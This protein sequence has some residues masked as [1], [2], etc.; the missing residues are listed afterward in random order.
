MQSN[1]KGNKFQVFE[2]TDEP[3]KKVLR[4]ITKQRLKNIGLFY[5]KRFE[6][7]VSNLRVVL[8]RRVDQYARQNPDFDR[9]Q[10]FDWIEELLADFERWGYLDDSR[11]AEMKIRDYLNAG[12]PEK[13]IKGKLFQK[14]IDQAQVEQILET[15]EYDPFEMALKL[16]RKKKIGP[17]RL[18]ETLR[19]ENRQKDMGVL[20]RA[21]FDYET[22][23]DVLNTDP[24][25]V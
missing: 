11:Y 2:S 9:L 16:A 25:S 8:R 7:S 13:Y 1:S 20:I 17:F 14:G 4:K 5:L 10:A 21:G 22:V 12:K 23:M 6:S 24:Q 3:K 18:D 15:K 19:T